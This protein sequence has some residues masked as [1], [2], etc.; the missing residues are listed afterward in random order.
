MSSSTTARPLTR[1]DFPD[2]FLFGTATAAY[3]IEGHSFGGAGVSH[4]DTFAATPG[5]VIRAE[6]GAVACDHYHHYEEDLDLLK[7]GN[8]DAYRFS[9]SWS[10]V[11]PEGRGAVN[12]EGID[13][14]DRLT[15][16]LL[17]RGLEPH[18]TLYHWDLPAALSDLGGWTN[19]DVHLWFGDYAEVIDAAIGDRMTSIATVN[20][21]W[22]VSY[23]SHILGH[24]A[25]GLRNIRAGAR[26]MHN[27]LKAHGEAI[28]RLRARGR[29]NLGIVLNF[30]HTAPA[31]DSEADIRAAATQDATHN[32]W[33]IEAIAKGS[34]PAEALEGLE[35][36]LPEGWQDDLKDLISQP[37]DWLG[38]NYYTRNLVAHD[39]ES[40]W[41]HTKPAQGHL[42]TTQMGWEI[43]PDGL[44][45]RLTGLARDYVG[46]LPILVTEN[47]MAWDDHL[48]NGQINDPERCAFITDHLAAMH[49]AI[50]DGVNLKGFFYWS[51]MD[52]FE[53]AFGFERRFGLVHVDFE[54][55]QRTPK[56]SYHM[57]KEL[58]ARS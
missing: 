14:Y 24:H 9:A 52:N 6:N 5:N 30:E 7:D 46:D 53:W 1:A 23:L 13:Y 10:R 19:P 50:E 55:L 49:R 36:H 48:R 58:I 20:E 42:A 4:W 45:E 18:L 16:A 37:L 51:L 2:G 33:F 22:C 17:E 38:A 56:A 26:S 28:R 25:P 43:Y 39:P 31:S 15:D 8:F 12:P 27:I 47:G 44:H 32:R 40:P 11:M 3:Q 35:E 57:F 54:S 34:Y 29:D 41:P 21:P